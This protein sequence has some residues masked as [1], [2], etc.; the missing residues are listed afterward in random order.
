[1]R[2]P[3]F[4]SLILHFYQSTAAPSC[5]AVRIALLI[6]FLFRFRFCF[7]L[8]LSPF[9]TS[10]LRSGQGENFA[11]PESK[12]FVPCVQIPSFLLTMQRYNILKPIPNLIGK[13]CIFKGV[14]FCQFFQKNHP[15]GLGSM[16]ERV[17]LPI[18]VLSY[19][20]LSYFFPFSKIQWRK[21]D[22]Y[23]IYI[24]YISINIFNN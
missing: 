10:F 14:F 15:D 12:F 1:M 11:R 4:G 8:A 6:F 13:N 5:F 24:L 2:P 18:S 23:I 20:V 9:T 19:F 7:G 22:L 17:C 3:I 21:Q 16:G